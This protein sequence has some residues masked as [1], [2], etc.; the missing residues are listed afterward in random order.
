M[1]QNFSI[2]C[3]SEGVDKLSTKLLLQ[4]GAEI[5][6]AT[7]CSSSTSSMETDSGMISELP[8]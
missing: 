3:Y 5:E 1:K 7:L 8:I 6:F 4:A 2:C